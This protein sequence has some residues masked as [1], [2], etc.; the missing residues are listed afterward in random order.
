MA[1]WVGVFAS[2]AGAQTSQLPR[3][4]AAEALSEFKPT[5]FSPADFGVEDYAL[6]RLPDPAVAAE[7]V[8]VAFAKGSFQWV[9][10]AK[11]VLVARA[12]VKVR[13]TGIDAGQVRYADFTH[14]FSIRNGV[15][16]VDVPVALL[17]TSTPTLEIETRHAGVAEVVRFAIAFT[18]RPEHRGRVFFDSSCT[19]SGARVLHGS[20]PDDSMLY[21][22]CRQIRTAYDD[23]VAA[24]LELYAAWVGVES[25]VTLDEV[26][27][28][29]V[30]DTLY[31]VRV[32]PR[33][34]FLRLR[35][36]Q[37][38][39]VLGYRAA[40]HLPSA[41]LGAGIGPYAFRY[42]D[43]QTSSDSWLPVLTIYAG[44]AF[45]P[46]TRVVYFNAMIP[47][48]HGSID[49]GLYLWL[50]QARFLDERM[51]FNLLLG[52]NVLVYR[53][54]DRTT[55]RISVPQGFELVARDLFTRGL[56]LQGGAFLYPEL[57][58]RSYYNLWLR[59]GTSQVFGELNYI[60][61]QEPD[62]GANTRSRVVGLS[63]G[64]PVLRFL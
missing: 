11:V 38:S 33:P 29:P 64:T 54:D 41:F 32:A 53:H 63:F 59:I 40:E 6:R 2:L 4:L 5:A 17:G 36:R 19:A 46:S 37:H 60:E 25:G 35:A 26:P 51:S 47:D 15:A 22:G 12:V 58:G 16:E 45:S 55:A 62:G 23:H 8:A 42:E 30:A 50:E 39:V 10:V 61:W 27:T 13:A 20:I 44:Y 9:R 57:K 43:R 48:E 34:G 18:P 52:G 49:Q 24:T 1:C 7:R 31:T 28:L 14:P 3:S 56:N 21:V